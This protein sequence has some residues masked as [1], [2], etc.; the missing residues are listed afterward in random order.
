MPEL[1]NEP[2]SVGVQAENES[3]RTLEDLLRLSARGDEQAFAELYDAV[4]PRAFGLALRVVRDRQLA[5]EIFQE[6]L[7]DVWRQSARFDKSKGSA[8]G[9]IFTIVHR[10]AVDR[11]RSQEASTRRD[12]TYFHKNTEDDFD[13]TAEQAHISLEGQRVRKAMQSLTATQ[14]QALE[15][16][17]FGGY[18]HTE[19]AA[20]LG[21]A[22]G[23][24]KTR[25]RDGLIRMRDTLGVHL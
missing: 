19:V 11:V 17:Y 15:L 24:A 8:I 12:T 7:L 1:A 16:A 23:T 13:S 21:I 10:S 25:I 5:E 22:L 4:A 20:L 2:R 9:W 6:A 18:T 14:R 3:A